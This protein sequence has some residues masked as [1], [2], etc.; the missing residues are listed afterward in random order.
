MIQNYIGFAAKFAINGLKI[1]EFPVS[2][3]TEIESRVQ[4]FPVL[5]HDTSIGRIGWV[6]AHITI[7]TE[8]SSNIFS[9]THRIW[10]VRRTCRTTKGKCLLCRMEDLGWNIDNRFC[11]AQSLLV[12]T[13]IN[14]MPR[15]K[16]KIIWS[17]NRGGP[18]QLKLEEHEGLISTKYIVIYA[19]APMCMRPFQVQQL[20][21]LKQQTLTRKVCGCRNGNFPFPINHSATDVIF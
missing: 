16:I 6:A 15:I 21:D 9:G 8:S 12:P 4:P 18:T 20:S 14:K 17:L 19:H 11:A 3:I 2:K 1:L 13:V 5:R 7:I 10:Y